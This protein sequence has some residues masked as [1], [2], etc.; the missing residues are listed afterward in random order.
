MSICELKMKIHFIIILIAFTVYTVNAIPQP[1]NDHIFQHGY[2]NHYPSAVDTSLNTPNAPVASNIYQSGYKNPHVQ[3]N[4][5]PSA[6]GHYNIVQPVSTNSNDQQTMF[7]QSSNNQNPSCE[8][9]PYHR[10]GADMKLIKTSDANDNA[11]I[12]YHQIDARFYE[13]RECADLLDV[14]CEG[15]AKL[16]ISMTPVP[17]P[18]PKGCGVR[19]PNG[20]DF[21]LTNVN[22]EAAF[23]EFNW[24]VEILTNDVDNQPIA[25]GS[26]IHPKAVLTSSHNVKQY[27]TRAKQLKVRAGEW[28]TQTTKESRPYQE[29][30]V[31]AIHLHSSFNDHSLVNDIAIVTLTEEFQMDVHIG[32]VCLPPPGYVPNFPESCLAS[33][34][35]KDNFGQAGKWSLILKK[36]QLGIVDSNTCEQKLRNYRL[37]NNFILDKSFICAGG[38]EGVDTCQGYGGAPLVCPTGYD[39]RYVQYG[40]VSWGLSCNKPI[41]GVY[42]NVPSMRIWIDSKMSSLGLGNIY[43]TY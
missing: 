5:Y 9:V 29:R 39:N 37:G 15:A 38:I 36:L 27:E 17:P 7:E 16:N 34:W 18:R 11:A 32:T 23:A 26:L 10:C 22:N 33:G 1:T 28:D 31:S 2:S 12:G 4:N 40:V 35:G 30:V 6:D 41:P 19:N 43:Y 14:C 8:C 42:A 13:T 25:G 24:V 3:Q 21:I 20:I